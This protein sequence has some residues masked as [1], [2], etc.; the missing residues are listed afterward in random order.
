MRHAHGY[1][2]ANK[3]LVE[4]CIEQSRWAQLLLLVLASESDR[5]H[6]PVEGV[7]RAN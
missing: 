6:N 4:C 2:T 5:L 1:L 7:G 3:G